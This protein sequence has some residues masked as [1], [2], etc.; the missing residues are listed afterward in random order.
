MKKL[1]LASAILLFTT[2]AVFAN[3]LIN[4]D[5]MS[6]RT[7]STSFSGE[8]A[9]GTFKL[10]A[11]LG[12]PSGVT[13]G[14]RPSDKFELNALLG[15]NYYGFTIGVSPLFTL[16]DIK[17]Q[18]QILPLSVGPAVNL[19]IYG[20]GIDLAIMGVVRWEYSFENVPINLFAEVGGGIAIY[21]HSSSATVFGITATAKTSGVTGAFTSA[22]GVRYIF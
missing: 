8:S 19:H 13:G 10:G 11:A 22:L 3:D 20:F 9:V 12:Y 21:S 4:A 17:I 1:F 16:V 2:W 15:T 7:E 6:K 5:L 14:W 18:D